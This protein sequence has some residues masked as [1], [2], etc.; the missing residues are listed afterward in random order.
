MEH[1]P[2]AI[3]KPLATIRGA[4][5]DD[6]SAV[7][8]LFETASLSVEVPAGAGDTMADDPSD[9]PGDDVR[10]LATHYLGSGADGL[11][12]PLDSVGRTLWVADY[13]GERCVGMV[14]LR[15]ID[16]D[17]AE[18]CRLRVSLDYRGRGIGRSLVSHALGVCR[19]RGYLKLTLDSYID[20][21]PA[22]KLFES[23]GFRISRTREAVHGRHNR[24]EFYLDLY[25]GSDAEG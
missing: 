3:E 1:D 2:A 5:L 24:H 9:D 11:E 18:M 22:I 12:D 8:K 10:D 15:H 7:V 17:N 25:R 14:G 23:F 19:D 20:R 21:G 4:E 13:A 16:A 6:Q